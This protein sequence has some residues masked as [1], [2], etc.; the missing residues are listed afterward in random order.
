[1]RSKNNKSVSLKH[2]LIINVAKNDTNLHL[3]K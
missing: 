2:L 3:T 1:M